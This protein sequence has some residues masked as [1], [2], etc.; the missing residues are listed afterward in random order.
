MHT[1]PN[2]MK[3]DN[4]IFKI[5]STQTYRSGFRANG[6]E[7]DERREMPNVDPSAVVGEAAEE[8]TVKDAQKLRV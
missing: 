6:N 5:K 3:E 4:H 7:G 2:L 8:A 1:L